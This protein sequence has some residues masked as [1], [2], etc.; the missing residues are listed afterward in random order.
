MQSNNFIVDSIQFTD[1]FDSSYIGH[2]LRKY[3]FNKN[4][5]IDSIVDYIYNDYVQKDLIRSKFK[6]IND[7]TLS[8]EIVQNDTIIYYG[9][10]IKRD[11]KNLIRSLLIS[12][13]GDSLSKQINVF[14]GNSLVE[15]EYF[16]FDKSLN[17]FAE[18]GR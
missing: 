15:Y 17:K 4:E 6:F 11:K 2:S 8:S 14:K 1:P 7:T 5:V 3:Y 13:N 9:L 16:Y 18:L 12:E 10:D